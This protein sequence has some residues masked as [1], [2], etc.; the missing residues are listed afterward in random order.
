MPTGVEEI[1]AVVVTV[2]SYLKEN[3]A[4]E[5]EL[6]WRKSINSSLQRI[7]GKVDYLIRAV[8]ELLVGFDENLSLRLL[9]DNDARFQAARIRLERILLDHP[10]LRSEHRREIEELA[11]APRDGLIDAV[12]HFALERDPA[13]RPY[14]AGF[15]IAIH[16]FCTLMVLATAIDMD[17]SG[18]RSAGSTLVDSLLRPCIDEEETGSFA[19]RLKLENAKMKD[20]DSTLDRLGNNRTWI[21]GTGSRGGHVGNDDFVRGETLTYFIAT[22]NG[23]PDAGYSHGEIR[24]VPQSDHYS[25]HPGVPKLGPK[26]AQTA[27]AILTELNAT[28]S[29]YRQSKDRATDLTVVVDGITKVVASLSTI[30]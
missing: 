22:F 10:R 19:Q 3:S 27:Y 26:A 24:E 29:D 18:V 15:P 9:S 23:T 16:G 1:V 4:E 14:F 28:A 11:K 13:R 25:K 17:R 30:T 2:V 8:R 12:T 6:R 20:L 5:K 21:V 7:E